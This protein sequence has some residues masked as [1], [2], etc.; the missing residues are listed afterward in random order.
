MSEP[1]SHVRCGMCLIDAVIFAGSMKHRLSPGAAALVFGFVV[2]S[3]AVPKAR[4]DCLE[5]AGMRYGV[6]PLLL[7][8]VA[9]QE[10]GMRADAINR[11]RDGSTDIGLMQI[12]SRWLPYLAR[13]GLKR[14]D[15]WDPCVNVHVGAWIM[16]SNFSRMGVNW[17]SLGAYN[18]SSHEQRAKYASQVIWRLRRLLRDQDRLANGGGRGD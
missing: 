12:N 14:D 13:H 11:N 6:S 10:S 2:F 7:K 5:L 3:L 9:M 4:A 17:V 1:V 8:A 15:L 16:A 18:A